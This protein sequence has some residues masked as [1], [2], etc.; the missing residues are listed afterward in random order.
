MVLKNISI[1]NKFYYKFQKCCPIFKLKNLCIMNQISH[2]SMRNFSTFLTIIFCTKCALRL[3]FCN[4]TTH[5]ASVTLQKWILTNHL[6]SELSMTDHLYYR[7][8]YFHTNLPIAVSLQYL[9]TDKILHTLAML[10][11]LTNLI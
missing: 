8:K 3:S 6:Q 10:D 7:E 4:W 2:F 1:K 9:F 5:F 11:S